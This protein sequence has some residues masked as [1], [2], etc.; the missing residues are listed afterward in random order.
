MANV[1]W[2][3]CPKCGKKFY[4]EIS[5]LKI[6]TNYHCPFCDLYFDREQVEEEEKEKWQ[7]I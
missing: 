2:L 6:R 3:T 1:F 5:M 4:A 7:K